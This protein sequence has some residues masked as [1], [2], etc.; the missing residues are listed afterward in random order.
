MLKILFFVVICLVSGVAVAEVRHI[1]FIHVN[2]VPMDR[3]RVLTDQTVLVKDDRIVAIGNNLPI[4]RGAEVIDGKRSL[5]LSPGLVDMHVHSDTRDDLP[6][7]L[8]NGITTI[9]NMGGA[10]A[11]FVGRTAPASTRGAI[12]GPRVYNAFVVDGSPE[13]GHFV[14]AS[15]NEARAAVQLAKSNG[16]RFIKT[17]NNISPEAFP[18][19]AE[20]GRRLQMPIVGHGVTRLGLAEQL[21]QGQVLVAHAE[22]FFYTF[23]SSPG[24]EQTDTP[25]SDDR[26]P[27]AVALVV[28]YGAAVGADLVTYGTIMKQIGHPEMVAKC[29]ASPEAAYVSPADRLAWRRSGY[30][31]RTANLRAKYAFL[32]RLLKAMADAGVELLAGTDAPAI[33]CI[34]PG[35]SLH[36]NLAALEAAGLSRFQ[37]LSTAT[38]APGH[39]LSRTLG[40]LPAGTVTIGSRADLILTEANPLRDLNTLQ[41]PWGVLRA[42]YWHDSA[43]LADMLRLAGQAYGPD[44]Q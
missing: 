42:G 23:F 33:P 35:V 43:K 31:R 12:A 25:P 9:S 13:Y 18:A 19:L 6:I 21:G 27:E 32:E 10:S 28:K 26:I 17:Y 34:G 2:V 30:V 37:V 4:P 29:L 14:A 22:E 11:S 40:E 36:H 8:A 39:F 41:R 15:P 24:S 5:W 44:S 20:E 7:Y 1:A 3:E 38:R 16:Y